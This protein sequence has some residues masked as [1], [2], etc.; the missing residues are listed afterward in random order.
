MDI[1]NL[2]NSLSK[3]LVQGMGSYVNTQ[4]LSLDIGSIIVNEAQ[5]GNEFAQAIVQ[6]FPNALLQALYKK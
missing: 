5:D 3:A 4:S 1:G 2:K 6:Q